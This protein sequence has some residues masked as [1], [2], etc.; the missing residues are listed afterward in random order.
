[1]ASAL[2][3]RTI[4]VLL[5]EHILRK[6]PAGQPFSWLRQG[7]DDMRAIPLASLFHGFC[8]SGMG[9]LL[10][11]LFSNAVEYISALPMRFVLVGPFLAIGL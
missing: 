1:M 5:L 2:A 7:F 8:F 9:T 3:C 10:H 6:V 11:A 4:Y